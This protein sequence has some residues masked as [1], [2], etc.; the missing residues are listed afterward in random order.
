MGNG[1]HVFRY[2]AAVA[3]AAP[4]AAD[5][6]VISAPS[7]ATVQQGQATAIFGVSVNDSI[8]ASNGETVTVTLVD[9]DGLLSASTG[10]TPASGPTSRAPA[11]TT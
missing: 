4:P 9:D 7:A 3:T 10:L 5:N 8:A 2:D 1:R 11:R 6:P